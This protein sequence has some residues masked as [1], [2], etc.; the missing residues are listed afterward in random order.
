MK[1]CIGYVR[2][3]YGRSA[4]K[5]CGRRPRAGEL[6]CANH[7]DALDSAMLGI[8]ELD[9]RADLEKAGAK[10]SRTRVGHA[11]RRGGKSRRP[12]GSNRT[13]P[14]RAPLPTEN[15]EV[16]DEQTE[17]NSET[18]RPDPN[19]DCGAECGTGSGS[20]NKNQL[21]GT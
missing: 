7:R 13:R 9:Q 21:N 17:T 1:T 8:M 11:R 12:S 2:A 5:P 19:G 4:W 16:A 15:S 10:K 20:G 6:L 3:R 14:A 18:K